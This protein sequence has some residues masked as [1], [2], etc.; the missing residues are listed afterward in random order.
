MNRWLAVTA[1]ALVPFGI[2]NAPASAAEFPEDLMAG[3]RLTAEEAE[4]L[5]ALL[6]TDPGHVLTRSKLVVYYFQQATL[7]PT[8]WQIRNQ[9]VL[10]LIR[11]A[12]HADVLGTPHAQIQPFQDATSYE[13]GKAAWLGHIEREPG[14][15]TLVGHAANFFSPHADREL[16]MDTLRKAQSLDAD[17]YQ[18]PFL[19]GHQYLRDASFAEDP[20]GALLALELFERAYEVSDHLT[21]SFQLVSLA[22]SAFLAGR[23]DEARAY[24][25]TML[26]DA[27]GGWDE[28][29]QLHHG[30]LILGRIALLEDDVESAKRH[31]LEAGKVS[32]SPQLG[33]FGPN[34]RLAADLLGRG[35]RDVVL[36][37][38]RLCANFWPR[39]ELKDWAALVEGGRTPDF[40]ANL[41]Y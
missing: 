24:A 33:S 40:G 4:R 25:T 10:W 14:N 38:F 3:M 20:A 8:V 31:L 17:N 26:E 27:P 16:S 2:G 23:Y 11:N 1:L 34:M 30:N 39:D 18:W 41:V 21:R 29:N 13:A 36:E 22:K 7:D 32:G 28:G 9:H 35:Q 19:L 6:E 15:V 12:P 37:Y 5:E